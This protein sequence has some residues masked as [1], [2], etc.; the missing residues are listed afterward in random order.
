MK[1]DKDATKKKGRKN[2][3]TVEHKGAVQGTRAQEQR[4][5][6][7]SKDT[8]SSTPSSR[9]APKRDKKTGKFLP[10]KRKRK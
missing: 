1:D 2:G 4:P 9:S 5:V 3:G 7:K 10:S 6:A 8:S